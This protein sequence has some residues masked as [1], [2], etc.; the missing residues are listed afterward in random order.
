[1]ILHPGKFEAVIAAVLIVAFSFVFAIN[2]ERDVS[3]ASTD[4]QSVYLPVIMYHH[5]T[6]DKQKAGKYTV[7]KDELK[8]DLEYI[9]NNGYN[10]VTVADLINYVQGVKNL[11]NKPIMITFDDGFESVHTLAY[12]LLTEYNMKAVVSVIG[13]VTEKYSQINDHNINYSNLTWDEINELNESGIIEI[14]NHSYD[15]HKS[16]NKSRKGISKLRNETTAE[17]KQILTEDLTR[18]Q[19]LMNENCGFTPTA[20]A[21]PYGAYNKSTLEIIKACGFLC[22]FTCEERINKITAGS[23]ETLYN[24]GRYNRESGIKTETFFDKFE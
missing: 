21:Y 6:E 16:D 13:S 17:Y 24:L 7:L 1:M 11:P 18:L 20:I 14:Q 8:N 10:T 3:Q 12:P 5:I 2:S 9:K 23:N 15:M 22:S 4:S 19:R